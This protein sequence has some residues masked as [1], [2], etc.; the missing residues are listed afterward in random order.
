MQ[1]LLNVYSKQP[2]DFLDNKE[3]VSGES[4]VATIPLPFLFLLLFLTRAIIEY[5]SSIEPRPRGKL[6]VRETRVHLGEK[7]SLHNSMS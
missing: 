3:I 7:R 1:L 6:K 4:I 5:S 2:G